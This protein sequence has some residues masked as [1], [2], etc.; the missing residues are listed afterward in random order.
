MKHG[1]RQPVQACRVHTIVDVAPPLFASDQAGGDER[2]QVIAD[3]VALQ[4]DGL[5][6]RDRAEACRPGRYQPPIQGQPDLLP[7]CQEGHSEVVVG[8][9]AQDSWRVGPRTHQP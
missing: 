5:C 7:E 9:A 6:E 4:S 1:R 2:L 8:H 3:E